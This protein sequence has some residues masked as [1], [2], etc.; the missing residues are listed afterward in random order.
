MALFL[1]VENQGIA[2]AQVLLDEGIF[3]L[4]DTLFQ[5]PVDIRSFNGY[6]GLNLGSEVKDYM[7]HS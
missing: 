4:R 2:A 7:I 1:F 6:G 5:L 3:D